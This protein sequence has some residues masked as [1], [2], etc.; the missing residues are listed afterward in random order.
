MTIPISCGLF[1]LAKNPKHTR[2]F[3]PLVLKLRRNLKRILSVFNVTMG[4]SSTMSFS[5][6]FAINMVLFFDFHA[7]TLL[8]KME[9]PNEKY[10]P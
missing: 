3:H 10:E 6:I 1:P 8:P 9:K 2:F 7:L 4:E 5:K